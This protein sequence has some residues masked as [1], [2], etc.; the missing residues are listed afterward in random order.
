MKDTIR[1]KDVDY[2]MEGFEPNHLVLKVLGLRVTVGLIE[3]T[4]MK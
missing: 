2:V 1:I 3:V 4:S